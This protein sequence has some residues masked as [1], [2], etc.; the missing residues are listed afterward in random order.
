MHRPNDYIVFGYVNDKFN[1]YTYKWAA[2]ALKHFLKFSP[3]SHSD[4]VIRNPQAEELHVFG[5]L[6]LSIEDDTGKMAKSDVG[7]E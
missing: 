3:A 2:F 4:H 6:Q 1:D 7:R 5:W